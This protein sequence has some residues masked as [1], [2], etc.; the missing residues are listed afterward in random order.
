MTATVQD[1][2]YSIFF[3]TAF[4][5]NQDGLNDVFRPK[6]FGHL[7]SFHID[8]YNRWGQ[9]IFSSSDHIK[10]WDGTINKI[11]QARDTYV[12]IAQYRFPGQ[13]TKT[14]KGTVVLIR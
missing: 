10:G 13:T 9:K 3:P 6:A 2:S 8:I 14:E 7:Q 4:S 5:P 11:P 12:W 1:C